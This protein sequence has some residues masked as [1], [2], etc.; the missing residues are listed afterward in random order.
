VN[1]DEAIDSLEIPLAARADLKSL[2]VLSANE[3]VARIKQAGQLSES[4]LARG[5]KVSVSTVK[6]WS[7]G[8]GEPT[9]PEH[10]ERL[11]LA[12]LT[13][14]LMRGVYSSTVPVEQMFTAQGHYRNGFSL[15][16]LIEADERWDELLDYAAFGRRAASTV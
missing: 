16:D 12:L 11:D 15:P 8:R 3:K 4:A 10:R 6:R 9:K 13:A 14:T 2:R 5:I 1:V 7:E